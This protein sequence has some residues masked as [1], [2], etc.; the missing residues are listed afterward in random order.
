MS[1]TVYLVSHG[2]YSDYTIDGVFSSEEKAQAYIDAFPDSQIQRY[3]ESRGIEPLVVD[4]CVGHEWGHTHECRI[5][6]K[7]GE[8][9]RDWTHSHREMRHPTEC[10]IDEYDH[11]DDHYICVESPISMDHAKK[12][13]VEKRQE[14]LRVKNLTP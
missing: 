1:Q 13:A 2:E 12:V 8:I 3:G 9:D 10:E 4:E 6:C 5:S 7:S 11:E 14:W